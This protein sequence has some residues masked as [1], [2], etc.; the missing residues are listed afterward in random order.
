MK[1]EIIMNYINTQKI[2]KPQ[3]FKCTAVYVFTGIYIDVFYTYAAMSNHT[4]FIHLYVICK[5][6]KHKVNINR[7]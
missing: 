1:Y 7:K 5:S 6:G 4:Q 3:T 2:S